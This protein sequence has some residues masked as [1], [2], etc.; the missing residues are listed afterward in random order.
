MLFN[1]NGSKKKGG[2]EK[3]KKK[4]RLTKES[5]SVK[6]SIKKV[7]KIIEGLDSHSISR[8]VFESMNSFSED[9]SS[10]NTFKWMYINIKKFSVD[11][12]SSAVDYLAT[13]YEGTHQAGSQA[14]S[15][16]G[17][18]K[19]LQFFNMLKTSIDGGIQSQTWIDAGCGAGIILLFLMV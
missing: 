7:A 18:M 5:A 12:L 14:E 16:S 11:E 8:P 1:I 6:S 9:Q 10:F 2:L 4:K 15:Q 17:T 13:R 19:S 3:E